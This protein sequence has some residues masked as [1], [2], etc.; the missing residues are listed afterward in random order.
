MILGSPHPLRDVKTVSTMSPRRWIPPF[1]HFHRLPQTSHQ[2]TISSDVE[3]N[4]VYAKVC[5]AK[6]YEGSIPTQKLNA[7]ARL[8]FS[9]FGFQPTTRIAPGLSNYMCIQLG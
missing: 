3:V 5:P 4:T 6:C 7:P 8:P 2:L 1:G 9:C